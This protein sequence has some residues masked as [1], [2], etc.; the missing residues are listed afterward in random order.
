MFVQLPTYG[1]ECEKCGDRFEVFQRITED[2]LTEHDGCGGAV[3]RL[4]Y[5]VGIVFKGPGFYVNDYA[6]GNGATKSEAKPEDSSAKPTDTAP[7][8]PPKA[9]TKEAAKPAT[10]EPVAAKS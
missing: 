1:Y 3:R 10:K 2:A 6:K 7:S 8:E 4:L 5:P 9:E